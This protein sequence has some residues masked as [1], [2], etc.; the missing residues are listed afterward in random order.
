MD[1]ITITHCTVQFRKLCPTSWERLE[2]TA[3]EAVRLCET[4]WRQVFRCRTDAEARYH[5]LEGHC[6][7]MLM[8]DMSELLGEPMAGA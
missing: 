2:P 6:V 3:D 1:M 7:A 4:C 5:A 8:P